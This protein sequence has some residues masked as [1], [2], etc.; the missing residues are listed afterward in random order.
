[1]DRDQLLQRWNAEGWLHLPRFFGEA[2]ITGINRVVDSLWQSKP[3]DVTVDDVD[4]KVRCRMSELS[5][6][7]RA[8]RVKI[9]DLYLTSPPV[10][11]M[12]LDRRLLDVVEALLD[13]APVL[14]NSLSLEKSSG[15]EYHADSL[16]MT[17]LSAGGVVACWIALEDVQT[18]SGPLRLYPASHVIEPFVFSDGTSH[19]HNTEMPRWADY[20]QSEIDSRGLASVSVFAKGGDLVIW[21]SD[22][23]HGAE[24]ITNTSSTR[25]SLVAHYYRRADCVRRGY[26]V[27]GPDD[28][29][30]WRRRPQPVDW[31]TRAQ[32]AI[33]RRVQRIRAAIR[34]RRTN[35]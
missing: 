8:H 14:C 2:E 3:R 31:F 18:G 4:R 7:D 9:S 6:S 17:P 20:M 12:L 19:A 27:D 30:W 15:Q 5:D 24:P 29:L 1:M 22:L 34:A 25:R 28:A 33:E 35:R 26:W 11:A 13:D 16:Y 32:C 10:R 23:L 21:H